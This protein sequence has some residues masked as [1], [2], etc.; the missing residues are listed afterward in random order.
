MWGYNRQRSSEELYHF[1]VLGM[2]WGVRRS[3][4]SGVPLSK[5]EQKKVADSLDK[6]LT[7]KRFAKDAAKNK[8]VREAVKAVA[9]L[10][11]DAE[12]KSKAAIAEYD[13]I[14]NDK[15]L[16]KRLLESEYERIAKEIDSKTDL[17]PDD[18][19]EVIKVVSEERASG[20]A[21]LAKGDRRYMGN[22]LVNMAVNRRYND[23]PSAQKAEK[24][25]GE[26]VSKYHDGVRKV[27]DTMLGDFGGTSM[28]KL[29]SS[30]GETT[31][32][33]ALNLAVSDSIHN[34]FKIY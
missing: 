16:V 25:H 29:N 33:D 13:K 20:L 19:S 1:G 3:I 17:S 4:K 7:E 32:R 26:A 22:E 9:P 11:K 5:D 24:E 2:R 15:G 14:I 21:S 6:S 23:T 27:V 8:Y 34:K 28:S 30:F 31:A 18:R 10:A 12:A